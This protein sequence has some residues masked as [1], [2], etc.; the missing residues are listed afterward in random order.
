MKTNK[1]QKRRT[2]SQWQDVV[3]AL[4]QSNLSL[5][6]FADRE[7]LVE[8]TLYHWQRRLRDVQQSQRLRNKAFVEVKQYRQEVERE[9]ASVS[10]ELRNGQKINF[11]HVP[12]VSYLA[13]LIGAL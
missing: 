6:E 9:S 5:K 10:L 1:N 12:S 8:K 2:A 7:G 11:S 3:Y 13:Q 4:N